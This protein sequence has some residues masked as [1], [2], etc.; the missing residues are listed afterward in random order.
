MRNRGITKETLGRE[1]FKNLLREWSEEKSEI[2]TTQIKKLG[3]ACDWSKEQF[4]MSEKMSNW[5]RHIFKQLYDQQ[6]IYRGKIKSIFRIKFI[7]ILK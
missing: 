1:N 6:M 7:A 2:I 5:V 3:C 4:T